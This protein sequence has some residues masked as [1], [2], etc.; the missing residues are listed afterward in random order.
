MKKS[1]PAANLLYEQHVRTHGY[2]RVVGLDE[3]GRGTWAGPVCAAAVA[4]PLERKNLTKLLHGVRDSKE[5]LP[6]ERENLI[7]TIK[8]TASAWGVGAADSGEVDAIGIVPATKLAMSRSLDHLQ[9]QFPHYDIQCL[10]LD[11]L[12]WPEMSPRYPQV[13]I[14]DGDARSL[15]IAA[16]SV[17]AKVWRDEQMRAWDALYPQYG[18]AAHKGYGS[19]RHMAALRE[20]GPCPLHRMSFKPLRVL[21]DDVDALTPRQQDDLLP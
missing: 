21:A 2:E 11:A 10:F 7:E 9:A 15:T 6:H 19:A 12:V 14:V 18:F 5:L 17:L 16:A 4:L 8:A 13:S 20:H 1:S 3:A